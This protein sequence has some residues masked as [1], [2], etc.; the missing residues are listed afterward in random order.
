MKL[1]EPQP[2][3][4]SKLAQ[5][6]RA[7]SVVRYPLALLSTA[8]LSLLSQVMLHPPS[9]LRPCARRPDAPRLP[10]TNQPFQLNLLGSN[11]YSVNISIIE[12]CSTELRA[13]RTV[14]GKPV[15]PSR[16]KVYVNGTEMNAVTHVNTNFT[17][18]QYVTSW[19]I[20][21]RPDK[22]ALRQNSFGRDVE[23]DLPE[24]Q[25]PGDA[26][27][28]EI[29]P[30]KSAIP[31]LA[32]IR[33]SASIGRLLSGKSAGRILYREYGLNSNSYTPASFFLYQPL[34]NHNQVVVV[35]NAAVS[36]ALVLR[37]IKAPQALVDFP[38]NTTNSAELRFYLPSQVSSSI[39]T[40]TG[41]YDIL[42]NSPF[43]VWRFSNPDQ[44]PATTRRLRITEERPGLVST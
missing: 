22:N 11:V 10:L 6:H 40:N 17:C 42:T 3:L 5:P 35:T 27:W 41:C 31:G 1:S 26:D 32:P 13:S 25:A 9:L 30:G 7:A 33:W 19:A 43:V 8:E 12:P 37:Q 23:V 39:N 14:R 38:T 21:I 20:E 18:S 24:S 15:T 16:L 44:N 4:L 29:G 28:P 2:V 34:T 36:N